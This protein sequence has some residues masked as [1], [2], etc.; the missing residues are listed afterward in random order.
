M[1]Q[2]AT[3]IVFPFV[4]LSVHGA[5]S[6]QYVDKSKTELAEYIGNCLFLLL[7]C[8]ILISV[9][10]FALKNDISKISSIR[11]DW[12]WCIIVFTFSQTIIQILLSLWQMQNKPVSYAALS[13]TQSV[14]NAGLSLL[15][16]VSYGLGWKGRISAQVIAGFLLTFISIFILFK[17]KW[18][19][20]TPNKA[21]M[22][23]AVS[24]GLPLI[25]HAL[26]SWATD[27]INRVFITNLVGVAE[28]GIFS[29]GYQIG[30]II[31]ILET[32]FIQAWI[33]Y[34]YSQLKENSL[35]IRRKLVKM[36]YIYCLGLAILA[37][38]LSFSAKFLMPIFVG[39]KFLV[40][41]KYIIWIAFGYSFSGMYKMMAGY[42]FFFEKTRVL[43]IITTVSSLVNIALTY[44]MVLKFGAI[45]AAYSSTCNYFITFVLTWS[46]VNKVNKMPWFSFNRIGLIT[47]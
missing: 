44:Y 34:L 26:A 17:Q 13:M 43:A 27:M 37:L 18:V 4:S 3:G 19:S 14:L 33:P 6:R 40:A 41:Q 23:N 5:I 30:M 22:I 38:M 1:F 11:K 12:L 46:M 10:F 45:G 7:A 32:S 35:E 2:V 8:T 47:S 28:T 39:D 29:V 15:F 31:S 24:F 9:I 25:P 42:F 16:I 20:F 21:F 36:T